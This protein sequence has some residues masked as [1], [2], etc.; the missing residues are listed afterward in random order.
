M[1]A[2]NLSNLTWKTEG[3]HKVHFEWKLCHGTNKHK[4]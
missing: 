4:T 2:L 3:W 1:S